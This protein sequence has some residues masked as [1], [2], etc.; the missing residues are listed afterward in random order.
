MSS[1]TT[2]R[3]TKALLSRGL[4]PSSPARRTSAP[5]PVSKSKSVSFARRTCVR[6]AT[7]SAPEGLAPF[8]AAVEAEV[9]ELG[10]MI[11]FD[12]PKD[13]SAST[14]P[15]GA[16]EK[17]TGEDRTRCGPVSGVE[18]GDKR[19]SWFRLLTRYCGEGGGDVDR[20]E[21]RLLVHLFMGRLPVVVMDGLMD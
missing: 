14:S 6:I 10:E 18:R 13:P 5:W 1:L 16:A 17:P 11:A 9:K 20:P 7:P 3:P 12:V 4:G 21:K 2:I 19:A 8:E 15:S